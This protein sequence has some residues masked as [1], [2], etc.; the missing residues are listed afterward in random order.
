MRL[1]SSQNK[2]RPHVHHSLHSQLF[3]Y[4]F[5]FSSIFFSSALL[6][7]GWINLLK[8]TV[9]VYGMAHITIIWS[10]LTLSVYMYIHFI[11]L[12]F[13][14]VFFLWPL[15]GQ[16]TF[17]CHCYSKIA[18]FFWWTLQSGRCFCL[19]LWNWDAHTPKR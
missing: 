6:H 17:F 9:L 8:C 13:V 19:S 4:R 16:K 3:W 14:W 10:P 2:C 7:I 1:D 11:C 5:C 12:G 15:V 18:L